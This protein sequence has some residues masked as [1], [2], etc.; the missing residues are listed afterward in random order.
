MKTQLAVAR[1]ELKDNQLTITNLQ[2]QYSV[3]TAQKSKLEN[4]VRVSSSSYCF[5]QRVRCLEKPDFGK[6]FKSIIVFM[7]D[8][9]KLCSTSLSLRSEYL[10]YCL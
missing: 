3:S 6:L 8:E 10:S 9:L 7:I 2:E 5:F 1:Q 4:Q